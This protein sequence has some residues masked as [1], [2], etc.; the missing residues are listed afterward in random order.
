LATRGGLADQTDDKIMQEA[1]SAM[2]AQHSALRA[3]RKRGAAKSYA[4]IVDL[5]T[6]LARMA[7]DPRCQSGDPTFSWIPLHALAQTLSILSN[8]D[9]SAVILGRR[10]HRAEK[11]GGKKRARN[12][13]RG[14]DGVA[15]TK[16]LV[17]LAKE[18]WPKI[19]LVQRSQ[20]ECAKRVAAAMSERLPLRSQI[21]W[22]TI[23]SRLRKD[24]P[25]IKRSRPPK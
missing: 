11:A 24:W 10:L 14:Y 3:A 21:G 12:F 19:P 18:F 7:G 15:G 13:T 25:K 2:R 5:L 22:R 23:E 4:A 6:S 8:I 20:N 1:F 9:A 16:E 17:A